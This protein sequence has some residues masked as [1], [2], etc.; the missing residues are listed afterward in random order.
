MSRQ[1]GRRLF[2]G[3]NMFDNFIEFFSDGPGALPLVLVIVLT[4]P[5]FILWLNVTVIMGGN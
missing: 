5:A 3:L 2:K 4:P 1:Q